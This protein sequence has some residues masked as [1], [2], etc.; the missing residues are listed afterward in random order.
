MVDQSLRLGLTGTPNTTYRIE[1]RSSLT[2][3]A[4][5]GVSTNTILSNG[6][7]LALPNPEQQPDHVLPRRVAGTLAH[8]HQW[9]QASNVLYGYL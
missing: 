9:S 4:W 8:F 1:K 6:F 2:S 7:N 5:T 3:G